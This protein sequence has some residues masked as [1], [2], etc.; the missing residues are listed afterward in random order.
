MPQTV[1]NFFKGLTV[2]HIGAFAAVAG[3]VAFWAGEIKPQ[4]VKFEEDRHELRKAVEKIGDAFEKFRSEVAEIKTEVKV[5]AAFLGQV[6]SLKTEIRDLRQD[7]SKLTS[8]MGY[9]AP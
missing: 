9:K 6:E 4:L 8:Q 1:T 5:Q 2:Q 3:F 7:M